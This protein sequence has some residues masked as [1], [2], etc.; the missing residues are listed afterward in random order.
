MRI[1]PEGESLTTLASPASFTGHVW[2][3]DVIVPETADHLGGIRFLYEPGARSFWHIH[4]RE[5]AII[6]VLGRGI[7]CWE[8]L[9]APRRLQAGDWWHVAPGVPHWHGATTSHP[10]AHFAVNAGSTHWLHEVDEA[11]YLAEPSG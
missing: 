5:Q 6:V 11:D 4:D 9:D 2:R 7:V 8:G 10:F 1:H 3:T